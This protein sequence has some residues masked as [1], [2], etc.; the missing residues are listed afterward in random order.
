[1]DNFLKRVKQALQGRF[2]QHVRYATPEEADSLGFCY[3]P[4]LILLDDGNWLFASA[5]DEGNEAGALFT[6]IA[7]LETI[8]VMR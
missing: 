4:L 7:G 1:M 6:S 5:D 2:I 8:G 3:K